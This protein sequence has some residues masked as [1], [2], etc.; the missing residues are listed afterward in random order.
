MKTKEVMM[1]TVRTTATISDVFKSLTL[2]SDDEID[3][4]MDNDGTKVEVMWLAKN[5]LHEPSY[6]LEDPDDIQVI[7][8]C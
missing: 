7:D 1:M 6:D 2:S 3:R 4:L 5:P 8:R